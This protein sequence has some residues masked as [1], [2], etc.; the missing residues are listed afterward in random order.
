MYHWLRGMDASEN[1]PRTLKP[2]NIS[3]NVPG[4]S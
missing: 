3:G 4:Y 1:P 2:R